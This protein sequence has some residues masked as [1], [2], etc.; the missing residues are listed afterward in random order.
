[1]KHILDVTDKYCVLGPQDLQLKDHDLASTTA[2][3]RRASASTLD[4]M[5]EERDGIEHAS[6]ESH[7][8][9]QLASNIV[10]STLESFASHSAVIAKTYTRKKGTGSGSSKGD[11]EDGK[12]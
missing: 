12:Q 8:P 7:L 5:S 10:R 9:S 4:S 1:M 3:P 2:R 11:E 6:S